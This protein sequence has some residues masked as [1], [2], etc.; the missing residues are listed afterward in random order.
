MMDRLKAF[1]LL[2][3]ISKVTAAWTRQ[4]KAEER[5]QRAKIN[6]LKALTHQSKISLKA[7]AWEYM[8]QGYLHA[9]DNKRLVATARQVMYAC[10]KYILTRTGE[11]SL[12]DEYFTQV[13]LPDF[14]EEHPALTADW[15]VVF[16][17]RGSLIEPHTQV[18]IPLGTLDVRAYLRGQDKR[19][20][21][22]PYEHGYQ[23]DMDW[24]TF[25]PQ[26]RYGAILFCEKET[27]LPLFEAEHLA[28]RYDIAI[29]STKGFSNTASRTVVDA[30]CR[31]DDQ[32]GL[33]LF[34]L[35]DFDID[36][37]GILSTL[38]NTTRRF[39]F[40]HPIRV[41]DMGLRLSDVE[42]LRIE[43]EPVIRKGDLRDLVI[44]RG[45][46]EDEQDYLIKN[47]V[48]ETKKD[49]KVS[50]TT[51]GER[52]E[53]NALTSVQLMDL[54]AAKLKEHQVGKVVPDGDLLAKAYRRAVALHF[55]NSQLDELHKE[56]LKFSA[57]AS[58]PD[59]LVDQVTKEL[60]ENPEKSWDQA[61]AE[62]AEPD[63]AD[64][65][66]PA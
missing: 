60:T 33:P 65:P 38:H 23:F 25:G 3:A 2:D 29:M 48:S 41:I 28:E 27:F 24:R 45:A 12:N 8:E 55:I 34:V 59:D 6:R 1:H 43:G 5:N 42:Q 47:V 53:L 52:V 36:G 7:A 57:E 26:H 14:M 56:A 4:R 63:H 32:A 30:L 54:I 66:D 37:L 40:N 46:T 58:L 31:A 21:R 19:E 22:D 49:D 64:E 13:L 44:E 18:R 20:Y 15:D 61:V 9:S 50:Y 16:D 51:M 62:L 17:A 10:R 39:Q 35:H 11:D